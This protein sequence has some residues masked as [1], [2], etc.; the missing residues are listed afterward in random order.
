MEVDIDWIKDD[1][2]TD[3]DHGDDTHTQDLDENVPIPQEFHDKYRS[4]P[5]SQLE[6]DRPDGSNSTGIGEGLPP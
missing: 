1:H 4:V 2:D 6:E 5:Q 3:I